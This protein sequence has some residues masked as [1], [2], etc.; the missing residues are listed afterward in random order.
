MKPTQ[1]RRL[2]ILIFGLLV[3]A[4]SSIFR[5]SVAVAQLLRLISSWGGLSSSF[6]RVRLPEF[7]QCFPCVVVSLVRQRRFDD[8]FRAAFLQIGE[9]TSSYPLTTPSLVAAHA[10][11]EAWSTQHVVFVLAETQMYGALKWFDCPVVDVN[12]A[13]FKAEVTLSSAYD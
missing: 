1:F 3:A 12:V 11:G 6:L 2:L 7:V 9:K 13:G 10:E 8:L 4:R 5:F